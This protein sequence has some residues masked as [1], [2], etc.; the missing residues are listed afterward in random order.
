VPS[1]ELATPANDIIDSLEDVPL[2][3]H[4]F[5]WLAALIVVAAI[6]IAALAVY[7]WRRRHRAAA[8][9]TLEDRARRRLSD[10]AAIPDP[11]PRAFHAELAAIVVGYAEERLGLRG[12]RLTTRE[13]VREFRRNAKMSA[14]WQAGLESILR[15]C[16][17]AKFAPH[18]D[19]AFDPAA[20]IA[21]CRALIDELAATA[22]ASPRLASPWEEW[23]NAA[24]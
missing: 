21:E 19:A 15:T 3:T 13:I 24:I 23:T 12:S 18:P 20:P 8:P 1:Q 9:V 7:L 22:A 6:A 10:L 4:D 17:R 14:A 16:D 2:P 5:P 11:D